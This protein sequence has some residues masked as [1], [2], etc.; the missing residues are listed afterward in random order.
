MAR[1]IRLGVR[2][3]NPWSSGVERVV[4]GGEDASRCRRVRSAVDKLGG[5][6]AITA[7]AVAAL[8]LRA[9]D[10]RTPECQKWLVYS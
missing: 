6:R 5:L 10:A 2:S 4:T 1:F 8:Q 9:D 7:A 3:R